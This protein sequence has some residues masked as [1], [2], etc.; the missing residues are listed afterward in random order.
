MRAL[1]ALTVFMGILIVVGLAVIIG[2]I[3]HRVSAPKPALTAVSA[4]VGGHA[5]LTLPPGAQI[6]AMTAV[7]ERLVLQTTTPDGRASLIT[8]DPVTGVVLETIDLVSQ[9]SAVSP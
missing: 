2:T 9:P 8:L 7:G 1:I 4:A 5:T 3:L 6:S